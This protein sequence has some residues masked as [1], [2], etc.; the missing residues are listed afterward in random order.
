MKKPCPV[1]GGVFLFIEF[2]DRRRTIG[3]GGRKNRWERF[4]MSAL[5]TSPK[6]RG[7][8]SLNDLSG[9]NHHIG[10]AKLAC[11]AEYQEDTSNTLLQMQIQVCTVFTRSMLTHKLLRVMVSSPWLLSKF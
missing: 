8:E 6:G 7:Q 10:V 11:K 4:F 9:T 2:G 3:E 1:S 5:P